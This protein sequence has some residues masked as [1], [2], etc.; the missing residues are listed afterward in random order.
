[1]SSTSGIPLPAPQ[2]PTIREV[3]LKDGI[4]YR[5]DDCVYLAPEIPSEP[6]K[7]TAR[8]QLRLG[9]FYR[10]KDVVTGT[11]RKNYDSRQ[12][13]ASM[14]TD[15]NPVSSIRGKCKVAHMHHIKNLDEY[16][17]QDDCFWY[18]QLYDRYTHRLYDVIPLEQVTH[19][20][21]SIMAVLQNYSFIFVEAGKG[22]DTDSRICIVCNGWCNPDEG[23]D[24]TN[25]PPQ[26]AKKRLLASWNPDES[27]KEATPPPS[28][29]KPAWPFRYFGNNVKFSSLRDLAEDK[30]YPK[31]ASRIGK[32]YQAEVPDAPDAMLPST[33]QAVASD[34]HSESSNSMG[35]TNDKQKNNQNRGPK[36]RKELFSDGPLTISRGGPDE[37][38]FSP[39]Y[40]P[41]DFSDAQLD[42]YIE[43]V[44]S[45]APPQMLSIDLMNTALEQ[46]HKAKYDTAVALKNVSNSFSTYRGI[47]WSEDE[48]K[49]FENDS[50]EEH[51]G[52]RRLLLYMEEDKK[53]P[54][55]LFAVLPKAST[56]RIESDIGEVMSKDVV[57]ENDEMPHLRSHSTNRECFNCWSSEAN[58]WL[59]FT[60]AA[61]R[62]YLCDNC[63]VN[64]LK[65]GFIKACNDSVRRLNREKARTPTK[66]KRGE[67]A[68]MR[69]KRRHRKIVVHQQEPEFQVD[70]S[71]PCALCLSFLEYESNHIMSCRGCRLRV[72]NSCYGMPYQ[73]D[74]RFFLCAHCLN[75]RDPEAS[76][77][78]SCV[79]CPRVVPPNRAAYKKTIGNNWAH[80]VCALWLPEIKFG[81][82]TS[83][84]VVE[85]VGSLDQ[86][87]RD[88]YCDICNEITGACMKCHEESCTKTCHIKCAQDSGW[89]LSIENDSSSDESV[90]DATTLA[91]VY[92]PDHQRMQTESVGI[93][94]IETPSKM[95][96]AT[97]GEIHHQD[98]QIKNEG[99]ISKPSEEVGSS[100]PYLLN[101]YIKE[102]K[103]R[104]DT[105]FLGYGER[106]AESWTLENEVRKH[107]QRL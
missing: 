83:L 53:I 73:S 64:W 100:L 68:D 77:I 37:V 18:Q 17:S 89:Q 27:S 105:K 19:L 66:R 46:L 90:S 5:V 33:D 15:I 16:T 11:R 60:N 91:V 50:I 81:D 29:P 78:Y 52:N 25:T 82:A 59:R 94:Q 55:Y 31:A 28:L 67:D 92:C 13:V 58:E 24:A 9:W 47:N 85:C 35:K 34:S 61:K 98:V 3:T 2:R 96:S 21:Q 69:M 48:I 88:V 10:S 80:L 22:L 41:A 56:K 101:R 44:K 23:N 7:K 106:R 40:M 30:G 79:L 63:A 4:T 74:N 93:S 86:D 26:D 87:K 43:K 12:L 39:N 42:E 75:V 51:E 104:E 107:M 49:R 65:Y 57:V 14:H 36:R 8:T 95:Y 32:A 70:E 99:A 45:I 20:P 103:Q 54:P 71:S 102:H 1:M 6:D 97:H 84:D 76:M 62:E 38:V 72:H